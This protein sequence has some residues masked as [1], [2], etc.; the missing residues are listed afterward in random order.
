[1][2]STSQAESISENQA[3]NIATRFMASH[4]MP[5]TNLRMAHKAPGLNAPSKSSENA[6]YYVFN[7]VQAGG[8]VIVAG[9]DRSPAVLGYSDKGTFDA[10][11]LPELQR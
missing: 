10:D 4:H 1:M 11:H 8:F 3:R 6:S 5:S 9:D 7:N 2:T